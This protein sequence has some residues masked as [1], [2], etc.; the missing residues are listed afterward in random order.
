MVLGK[1]PR[2]SSKDSEARTRECRATDLRRPLKVH[3]IHGGGSTVTDSG[4]EQVYAPVRV[5]DPVPRGVPLAEVP[6]EVPRGAP[7]TMVPT[8][9]SSKPPSTFSYV[10]H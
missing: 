4:D 6:S 1:R 2:D 8:V 9:I 5:F 7:L 10:H 3:P